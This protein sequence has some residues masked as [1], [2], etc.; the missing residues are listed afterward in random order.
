MERNISVAKI[1]GY[2]L[3]KVLKAK[4]YIDEIG[5]NRRNFPIEKLVEYYNDIHGTKEVAVGC[6]PCQ[7]S[8]FYNGIM[9]F[10]QFGKTTLLVNGLA[11]ESDFDTK[12]KEYVGEVVENAENRLIMSEEPTKEE[13]AANSGFTT[14]EEYEAE[15]KAIEEEIKEE[16]KSRRKNK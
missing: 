12:T 16:K 2:T 5:K 15:V 8:K 9:N 1:N 7:S 10:Y 4:A 11:T 3:E 13:L 14:V 6:K